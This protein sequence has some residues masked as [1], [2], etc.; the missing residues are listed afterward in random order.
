MH[1]YGSH[2][3]L[4]DH[5]DESPAEQV[6]ADEPSQPPTPP[7]ERDPRRSLHHRIGERIRTQLQDGSLRRIWDRL[8][9]SDERSTANTVHGADA[10][11]TKDLHMPLNPSVDFISRGGFTFLGPSPRDPS[12]YTDRGESEFSLHA[13]S[14]RSRRSPVGSGQSDYWFSYEELLNGSI[15]EPCGPEPPNRTVSE[16]VL[17]GEEPPGSDDLAYGLPTVLE[18]QSDDRLQPGSLDGPEELISHSLPHARQPE[19]HHTWAASSTTE[20]ASQG[21]PLVASMPIEILQKIY[22]YFSPHDFNAA[23]HICKTWMTAS[24]SVNLLTT[25]LKRGG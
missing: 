14:G 17:Y 23:R 6:S 13:G 7:T 8:N 15:L 22:I 10:N 24:L 18:H 16:M 3:S 9:P 5:V 11:W 12:L 19:L 4:T 2:S 20:P 1:R 21:R 25:M